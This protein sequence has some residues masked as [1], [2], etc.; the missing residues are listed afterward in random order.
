M[1]T[2][3]SS[4]TVQMTGCLSIARWTSS[5]ASGKKRGETTPLFSSPTRRIWSVIERLPSRGSPSR[6]WLTDL[7][8]SR[9]GAEQGECTS[10]E[11]A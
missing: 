5:I 11:P 3:T 4:C 7:I 8:R 10:S 6:V 1:P 2:P 9:E